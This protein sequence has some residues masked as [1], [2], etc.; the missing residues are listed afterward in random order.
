MTD[1][2]RKFHRFLRGCEEKFDCG[3]YSF[4]IHVWKNEPYKQVLFGFADL[5][6]VLREYNPGCEHLKQIAIIYIECIQ[7]IC[8]VYME[9]RWQWIPRKMKIY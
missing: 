1:V 7:N 3:I 8:K 6:G 2:N 5:S 9:K 4:F